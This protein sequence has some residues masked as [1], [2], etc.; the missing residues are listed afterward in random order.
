[1]GT[2]TWGWAACTTCKVICTELYNQGLLSEEVYKADQLYG[3]TISSPAAM[4]VYSLWGVPTAQLM[5]KSPLVT[6]IVR[7]L[8]TAWAEHMAHEMGVTQDDT[9]LGRMLRMTFSPLHEALGSVFYPELNNTPSTDK[10]GLPGQTLP[11]SSVPGL[12][13]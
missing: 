6:A 2:Y 13:K 7:P 9:L 10:P 11:V 5:A 4:K 1:M 8:A 3:R 12:R